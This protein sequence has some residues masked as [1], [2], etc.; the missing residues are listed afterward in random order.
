M[1]FRISSVSSPA[2][3]GARFLI[4]L[5]M[6]FVRSAVSQAATAWR[7]QPFFRKTPQEQCSTS[8]RVSV[9]VWGG[10]PAIV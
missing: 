7:Q 1:P 8:W 6:T 4:M 10:V 3:S 5:S 9:T 2:I